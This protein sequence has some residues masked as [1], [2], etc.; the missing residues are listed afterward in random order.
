MAE[1]TP[2]WDATRIFILVIVAVFIVSSLTISI[3]VIA[4]L[5]S[6][7]DANNNVSTSQEESN[8]RQEGDLEGTQLADF[9]PIPDDQ[10]TE[11]Q[12][13]DTQIGDG[14]EAKP[15]GKVTAH[16]TGAVAATGVIFQS[17]HDTGDPVEFSLDGVIK[18]WS[19]GVPGMKVGGKRRLIIPAD[20]AYGANPPQGSGIPANAA[21]VFDIELVKV[22]E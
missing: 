15:G 13:I 10:V 4:E 21:L 17:S 9:T 1:T 16:Y 6:G 12:K 20:Q 19:D 5:V 8:E 11:L 7:D 22:S 18:G 14:E 2:K 3:M